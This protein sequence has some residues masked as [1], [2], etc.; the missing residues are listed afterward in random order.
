MNSKKAT[1]KWCP[2]MF[3]GQNRHEF[4]NVDSYTCIG[5]Q[6]AWF[7]MDLIGDMYFP[8]CAI[9]KTGTTD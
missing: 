9:L 1:D 6:C 3:I 5:E 7:T 2:M 8:K 4:M